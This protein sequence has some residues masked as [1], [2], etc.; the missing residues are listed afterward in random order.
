[1]LFGALFIAPSKLRTNFRDQ[2]AGTEVRP[3]VTDNRQIDAVRSQLMSRFFSV[4][5]CFCDTAFDAPDLV[6]VYV[7]CVL[8]LRASGHALLSISQNRPI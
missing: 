7:A 5:S 2:E 8:P 4:K 1:M 6:P 3:A